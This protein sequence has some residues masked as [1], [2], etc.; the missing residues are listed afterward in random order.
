MS[1]N[2]PFKQ[3]T[4]RTKLIIIIAIAVIAI[5][6]LGVI[7]A[8]TSLASLAYFGCWVFNTIPLVPY[9]GLLV[10]IC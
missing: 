4:L 5:T 2:K 6:V 8:V 9:Y 10:D 1:D 3:E 7:T